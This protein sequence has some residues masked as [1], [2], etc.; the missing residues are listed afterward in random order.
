MPNLEI[1]APTLDDVFLAKTGKR[2]EGAEATRRPRAAADRR[3]RGRAG[4][5]AGAA[6]GRPA[7]AASAPAL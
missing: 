2:L 5:S 3:A 7:L 1:H 6:T 4:V